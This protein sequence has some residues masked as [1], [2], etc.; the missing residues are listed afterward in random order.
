MF[1]GD[2]GKDQWP[3]TGK[4]LFKPSYI[5]KAYFFE[6][7]MK[8]TSIEKFLSKEYHTYSENWKAL[9]TCQF[10]LQR[11]KSF[12]YVQHMYF[13]YSDHKWPTI[14][15]SQKQDGHNIYAIIKT[16]C[17]PSYH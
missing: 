14:Q 2:K 4:A 3:K 5:Q 6:G 16:M 11:L 12:E 10:T 13:I 15:I 17:P 1:S 7:F 9:P 8:L